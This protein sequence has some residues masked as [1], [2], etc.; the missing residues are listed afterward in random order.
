MNLDA[1]EDGTQHLHH[2]QHRRETCQVN[3]SLALSIA[4]WLRKR[5]KVWAENNSSLLM[6]SS[7]IAEIISGILGSSRVQAFQEDNIHYTTGNHFRF[8]ELAYREMSWTNQG[9]FTIQVVR[10][11]LTKGQK[12]QLKE[13]FELMDADGS[14]AIDAD[15]L[16]AAFKV[17]R[18]MI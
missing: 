6:L 2:P 1:Y 14:G 5:G 11:K 15:E 18:L 10:P 9:T 8:H 16:F 4:A 13:C 3:A 7:R 17:G 12:I